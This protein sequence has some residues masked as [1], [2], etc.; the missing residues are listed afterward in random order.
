MPA[1]INPISE[2]ERQQVIEN[3]R[4]LELGPVVPKGDAANAIILGAKMIADEISTLMETVERLRE[5]IAMMPGN[6]NSNR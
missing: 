4:F 2:R 6:R 1:M 3:Y 5:E